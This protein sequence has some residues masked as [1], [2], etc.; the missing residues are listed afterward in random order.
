MTKLKCRLCDSTKDE[1]W[2]CHEIF[3]ILCQKC[4]AKY[5]DRLFDVTQK[6]ATEE[7]EK[8]KQEEQENDTISM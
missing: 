6:V 1:W 3:G 4:I 5:Y 8:I 7:I 2:A